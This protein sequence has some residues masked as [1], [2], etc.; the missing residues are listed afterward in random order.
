MNNT[1]ED[2]RSWPNSMVE[3]YRLSSRP[4]RLGPA[5]SQLS[6]SPKQCQCESHGDEHDEGAPRHISIEGPQL[7]NICSIGEQKFQSD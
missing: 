1:E 4:F 2:S 5:Q 6:L 3:S 7:L